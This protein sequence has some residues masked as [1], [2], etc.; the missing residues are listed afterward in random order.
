MFL[1]ICIPIY[2]TKSFY[3]KSFKVFFEELIFQNCSS[4]IEIDADRQNWIESE[5]IV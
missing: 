4:F 5:K 1:D 3:R 2:I